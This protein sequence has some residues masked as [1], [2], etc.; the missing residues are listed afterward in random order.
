ML[1]FPVFLYNPF[2]VLLFQAMYSKAGIFPAK[3]LYLY[4]SPEILLGILTTTLVP[5]PN[6]LSICSPYASP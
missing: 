2:S 6:L 5:S 1:H 4:C 3:L